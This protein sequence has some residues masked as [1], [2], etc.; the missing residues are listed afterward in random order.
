MSRRSS[1]EKP[2]A[3]PKEERELLHRIEHALSDE[4][5]RRVLG[6]ALLTLDDIGRKRLCARLAP[7]TAMALT[8]ALDPPRR[9]AQASKPAV[10]VAGKGKL[11]QEWDRL[12][13]EWEEVVG[14]TGDEHGSYVEQD[15]EWEPPYVVTSSIATDLDAIAKRMR[16]LMPRVLAENIAPDFSFAEAIR[17]MDNALYAGLPDW[18]DATSGDPCYLGTEITACLIEWEW[19]VARREGHDAVAFLDSIRDLETQLTKVELDH[20]TITTFVLGLSEAELRGLL[21]SMGRQRSSERWVDAFTQAHGCWAEILRNLAKRWDPALFADTSRAN[22]SQDWTLALPLVENTLKR[23]AFAEAAVIIDEALG[24][25][26]RL[27]KDKRWNPRRELLVQR[28]H[29]FGGEDQ[30]AKTAQLLHRWQE[31]AQAQGQPDLDAALALQIVAFD[32]V[33]DGKHMLEAFRAFPHEFRAIRDTLFANW[34]TLIVQRTFDLW[35]GRDQ[36]PCGD[37]L[38][39]LVDAA[40]IGSEGASSF[41]SAVRATLEEAR[42]A[43]AAKTRPARSQWWAP[44]SRESQ[45]LPALAVLTRDLDTTAPTLKDTAP[46]LWRLLPKPDT[47]ER[48]G[49]AATRRNWCKSLGGR[50]LV[51]E[52]VA[53]WRENT[54]RF[55]PDPG[56]S[57]ADYSECADWLAAVHEINPNAASELLVRWTAAHRLKRNL[58]RDLA[59][60]GFASPPGVRAAPRAR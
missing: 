7:E 33:E 21:A 42:T 9:G 1:G 48:D 13:Q 18:M 24:S 53:F 39:A 55:V 49:F 22:I 29:S 41:H 37:W 54:M 2:L 6:S 14:E 15:A 31:T 12:W 5:I 30:R 43:T 35:G 11:R 16:S 50:D 25:K 36:V 60:R 44:A 3:V 19:T 51:P 8:A 32:R 56:N 27:D 26:L 17:D 20:K 59:Q 46:R 34:R 58:W 52:I 40:R 47:G 45:S 38:P 57:T 23:K 4:E 10:V 28:D